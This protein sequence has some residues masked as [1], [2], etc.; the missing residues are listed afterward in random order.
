MLRRKILPPSTG[1][2]ISKIFAV[3]LFEGVTEG[4]ALHE[5]QSFK[6][7]SKYILY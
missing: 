2:I 4:N 7:L 3:S 1:V 6:C 5:G